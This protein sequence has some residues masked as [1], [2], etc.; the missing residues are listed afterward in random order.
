MPAAIKEESPTQSGEVSYME[1]FRII[2]DIFKLCSLSFIQ[3]KNKQSHYNYGGNNATNDRSS[4]K[5]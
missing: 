2:A 3:V 1:D 4:R 5:C